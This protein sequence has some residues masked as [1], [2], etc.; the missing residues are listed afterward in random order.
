ML[1]DVA[2]SATQDDTS[3]SCVVDISINSGFDRSQEIPD[4]ALVSAYREA[5]A[6]AAVAIGPSDRSRRTQNR[7]GPTPPIQ[8]W[9]SQSD[10]ESGP[11]EQEDDQG[12]ANSNGNETD[13][14]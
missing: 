4:N 11:S 2:Q 13:D 10:D 6:A 9:P 3:L 8:T 14:A 1:L 7:G 5:M 12:D